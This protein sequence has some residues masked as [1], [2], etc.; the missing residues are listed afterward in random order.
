[1]TCAFDGTSA[2]NY[3]ANNNF[4]CLIF[5]IQ[6]ACFEKRTT[7]EHLKAPSN[8][9]V[10]KFQQVYEQPELI[11]AWATN[12][13]CLVTAGT[14]STRL[15]VSHHCSDK[16]PKVLTLPHETKHTTQRHAKKNRSKRSIVRPLAV[17]MS[18]QMEQILKT[19]HKSYY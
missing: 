3:A 7:L 13:I 12:E 9:Q 8:Q 6:L 5:S 11:F 19:W 18:K 2:K 1:M 4:T 16:T 15:V 10:M 14:R 17:R